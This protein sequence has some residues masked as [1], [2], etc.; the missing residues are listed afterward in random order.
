MAKT[1][2]VYFCAGCGFE[3]ARWLGRCPQCEA[4]NSFDQTPMRVTS[5]TRSIAA[6]SRALSGP[7]LLREVDDAKVARVATGLPEF[8]AVL[9]GGI[10]PGSLTLVGGPPGAGKSTL[11]LQ[12]A[13]ALASE[14]ER[15]VY[16]CGEESAAQVKLRAQRLDVDSDV[17]VYAET[18]LR[19]VLETLQTAPP[20]A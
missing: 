15:V 19:E 2:S 13:S 12:I 5:G 16:I 4:W 9:G 10:V 18:N 6:P 7:V 20:R 1:R 11:L 3:S 17:L 8:D 14:D